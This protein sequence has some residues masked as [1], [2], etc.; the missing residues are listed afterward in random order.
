V[1]EYEV[2]NKNIPFSS[3]HFFLDISFMLPT[4]S[5]HT[6]YKYNKETVRNQ[7]GAVHPASRKLKF[8]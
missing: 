2:K 5:N 7:V 8:V 4:L 3:K 1:R 6:A